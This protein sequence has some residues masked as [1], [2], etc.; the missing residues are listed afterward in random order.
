VIFKSVIGGVGSFGSP[1]IIRQVLAEVRRVLKPGGLLLFAENQRGSHF[2]RFARSRFVPWGRQW[3]YPSLTEL[4]ELLSPFASHEL[5]SYGFF[6]C[7]V[8]DWAPLAALD[9]LICRAPRSPRHYMAYG[10]AV[11]G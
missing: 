7:C 10:S 11:V 2:H 5:F 4:E 8:K 9:R 6:S 1:A 3:Y